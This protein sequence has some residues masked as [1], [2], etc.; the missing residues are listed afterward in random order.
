MEFDFSVCISLFDISSLE[1]F[2]LLT[3]LKRFFSYHK[4]GFLERSSYKNVFDSGQRFIKSTWIFFCIDADETI[5]QCF[6]SYP[7]LKSRS[8]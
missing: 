7:E 3:L 6:A 8:V 5:A 2:F 4:K 1:T